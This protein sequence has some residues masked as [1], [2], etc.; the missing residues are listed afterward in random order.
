M[1]KTRIATVVIMELHARSFVYALSLV[2][3]GNSSTFS[4]NED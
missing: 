3:E 1:K 4:N 2:K